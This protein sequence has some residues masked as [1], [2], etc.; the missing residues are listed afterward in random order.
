MP[1]IVTLT[2]AFCTGSGTEGADQTAG[3]RFVPKIDSNM[4]G[5][6]ACRK[7]APFAIPVI[8]GGVEGTAVTVTAAVAL[9][10]LKLV[11]PAYCA[12]TLLAPTASND[13]AT[14]MLAEA[15][16]PVP[17]NAAEAIC[18]PAA[19]NTTVPLG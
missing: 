19:E 16:A 4:P 14:V 18:L 2:P 15:V 8:A 10:A 7:E 1:P 13:A 17:L 11:S 5:A 6:Y 12:T 9:L 3:A